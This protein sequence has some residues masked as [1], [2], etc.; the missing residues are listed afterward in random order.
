MFREF[1]GE[2]QAHGCLNLAGRDRLTLVVV[3]QT[4]SFSGNSFEDVVHERV[5]DRHC[6][7][8]NAGVRVDLL[9]DTVDVHRVRFL[10]GSSS[11]L[12]SLKI[13]SDS[14]ITKNFQ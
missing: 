8:R 11:L 13:K 1:A 6:F 3:S 10:A 12:L 2:D 9:E 7:S 14:K 5:L 4:R